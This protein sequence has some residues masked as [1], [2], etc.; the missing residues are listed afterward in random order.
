MITMSREKSSATRRVSWCQCVKLALY[1]PEWLTPLRHVPSAHF[2][3]LSP[4][5]LHLRS[6]VFPILPILR[7][8]NLSAPFTRSFHP[9]LPHLSPHP[10]T[11]GISSDMYFGRGHH[12]PSAS[13]EAQSRLQQF[14]GAT[15]IS[16]NA[17]FGRDEEEDEERGMS[18]GG[19][20]GGDYGDSEAIQNLERG[21]RDMAG[22]VM[23]SQEVQNLTEQVR[24]G[25]LKVSSGLSG[26]W[27]VLGASG[28][29]EE[30]V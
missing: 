1:L 7:H 17:Y 12:D 16:S 29:F 11:P 2:R 5:H 3:V 30:Y 20:G 14:S 25:A 24:A 22:R 28:K 23:G 10:L 6:N 15:A 8:E 27:R 19:A 18:G 13:S 21:I 9:S 26:F 4:L